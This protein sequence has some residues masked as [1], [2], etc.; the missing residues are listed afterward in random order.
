MTKS[1]IVHARLTE[2]E[3]AV[4][5]ALPGAT[6]SDKLRGLIVNAQRQTSM[7]AALLAQS[8]QV[9]QKLDSLSAAAPTQTGGVSEAEFRAAL[10]K[11]TNL[12]SSVM[13]G[14]QNPQRIA[15]ENYRQT[16]YQFGQ[17]IRNGEY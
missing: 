9:S 4:F 13:D 1:Q 17:Q 8:Q 7:I 10:W 2:A 16:A 5:N 14:I 12:I 15:S 6:A 11:I 3:S